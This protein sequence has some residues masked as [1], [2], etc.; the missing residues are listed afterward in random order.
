MHGQKKGLIDGEVIIQLKKG[1][2][3]DDFNGPRSSQ[4]QAVKYLSKS[5]NIVLAK[6]DATASSYERIDY[7]LQTNSSV[8]YH[9]QN[10]NVEVRQAPNDRH[11]DKQWNLRKIE[12]DR[13]WDVTTGGTTILGDDIVVAIMDS[14][15]DT[16]LQDLFGNINL[17]ALEAVG[18]KNNDGC[19]G[20]CGEDDDN[21]GKIDEDGFDREPGHPL[22]N[23]GF[24]SDDD[25]NGY[26]DDIKGLNLA[27]N[28]D[29][30]PSLNHGTAVAGIIGAIGNNSIGVSG[31]NWRVDLMLLSNVGNVGQIIEAYE[32]IYQR[33]KLYNDSGGE[34]GEYIVVTNFSSGIDNEFGSDFPLWCDMY[35][36]L[37]SVGVLSV[38]ATTNRNTDVDQDGDM[39]TTCSS[40]YL[41]AVT[42]LTED[43]R[44][45]TAGF[46]EVNV[47]IGAPGNG[48]ITLSL[49][50]IDNTGPFSGTSAATPHVAGA[51]ALL[52]SIPCA[53]FATYFKENPEKVNELKAYIMNNVDP[54]GDLQGITK[55]EGRLN[56]YKTMVALR[57]F[58]PSPSNGILEIRNIY[59]NPSYREVLRIKYD[60]PD[61]E[62]NYEW[63]IYDIRGRLLQ[64]GK[65]VPPL[66]GER[67]LF[68]EPRDLEAGT[69]IIAIKNSQEVV[70][71]K[72]VVVPYIR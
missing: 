47:D 3:L 1:I 7:L 54:I 69:Y 39:P 16:N 60:G 9:K 11:Y 46:G 44:K 48:S 24:A 34:K 18:D 30:H 57:D 43:D 13:A 68:L 61:Q 53:E 21:D 52:H 12:A 17:N 71:R 15:Y 64:S 51:I 32:Y 14:G 38:G 42:N 25:E 50:E 49:G 63:L 29:D 40:D 59:P 37:G 58:C 5:L 26:I 10:Q 65:F 45:P 27:D 4:I 56:I 55:S 36:R 28:S 66:Y 23:P 41:I 19:P 35:D 8:I 33:R 6:Y 20:D 31:I 2:S 22:Y 70:A 67:E 72:H 62:T